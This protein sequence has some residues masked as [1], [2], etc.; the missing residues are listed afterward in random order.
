M[1]TTYTCGISKCMLPR[2]DLSY[3]EIIKKWQKM[4]LEG[5]HSCKFDVW[6]SLQTLT[7]NVISWISFGSS[8]EEGSRV[9]VLQI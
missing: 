1:N 9:F 3:C 8:Y 7:G 6:P 4:I 5:R 2:F